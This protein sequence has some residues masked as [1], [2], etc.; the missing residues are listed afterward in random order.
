MKPYILSPLMGAALYIGSLSF[1]AAQSTQTT[2]SN[3]SRGTEQSLTTAT[4]STRK[5]TK[6]ASLLEEQYGSS[7]S[8][9]TT[10][11][12]AKT[13]KKKYISSYSPVSAAGIS[14]ATA[15][16]KGKPYV[17]KHRKLP[18]QKAHVHG[19]P[20][21]P[22]RMMIAANDKR[23]YRNVYKPYSPPNNKPVR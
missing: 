8:A 15:A 19:K 6:S 13:E 20:V 7:D 3:D 5:S 12:A 10:T 22:M 23:A 17:K 18:K 16:E 11:A 4:D 2:K 1:A 14:A 9:S 21:Y